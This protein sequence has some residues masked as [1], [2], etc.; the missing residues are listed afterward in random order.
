[1]ASRVWKPSLIS[2]PSRLL[3]SHAIGSS[4]RAGTS[5]LPLF[6]V[7]AASHRLALREPDGGVGGHPRQA[8][9][10]SCRR[11]SPACPATMRRTASSSASWPET[12]TLPA[13]LCCS[14]TPIAPPAVT[15]FDA[16]I[17][18]SL[19]PAFCKARF[20]Q[21]GGLIR[22]PVVRP[23]VADDAHRPALD[24]RIEHLQLAFANRLGVRVGRR[25]AN[26]QVVARRRTLQQVA[27]L[28][29]ANLHR[30]ECRRTDRRRRCARAG[31]S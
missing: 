17:A 3:L 15:S 31:R 8:V 2:R 20:G 1:M 10:R 30:I 29:L 23:A 25:P 19:P 7:V 5:F 27:G 18:D 12:S 28:Q 14:S 26:Q 11:S 9:D 6:T 16:T 24:G 4:S 22:P 13:S 21:L